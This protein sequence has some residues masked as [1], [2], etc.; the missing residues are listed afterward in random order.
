MTS[1]CMAALHERDAEIK[2]NRLR[3]FRDGYLRTT[4]DGAALID[5]YYCIAPKIVTMID[6]RCDRT[7]I[8]QR[9]YDELVVTTL[10][11]LANQ[12]LEE[13]VKD[14]VIYVRELAE[15]FFPDATKA[16]RPCGH[17]GGSGG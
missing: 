2:L 13:A 15:D 14:Y 17:T 1:A 7:Q 5:E 9:I 11:H 6:S 3:M 10:E 8:Y 12:R 4:S 16:N